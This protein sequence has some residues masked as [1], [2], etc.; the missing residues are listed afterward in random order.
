MKTL[1]L[2]NIKKSYDR[3]VL[4]GVSYMFLPGRLYVIKGV[5]GCGKSTLFNI[6]GGVEEDFDGDVTVGGEKMSGAQIRKCVGYVYQNSLLLSRVSIFDNLA[7]INGDRGAVTKTARRLGIEKHLGKLPEQ[8]SGGER[9]R[10]AVA[11]SLIND[12]DILL[13]DEPTASL[14][15]EN[16]RRT[17]ELIASLRRDGRIVLVA[18]HESCFD[19]LADE[20]LYL[21]YGQIERVDVRRPAGDTE[22]GAVYPAARKRE[23]ARGVNFLRFALRRRRRSF[24]PA[25]LLP[26]ALVVLLVMLVSTAAN[27]F[28]AEYIRYA[29]SSTI[30]D[31]VTVT[32]E[33]FAE[34]DAEHMAMVRRYDDLA[35]SDGGVTALYLADRKDSWLSLPG[36][37]QYGRFP[38]SENE[39]IVSR[40]YADLKETATGSMVGQ[41]VTFAG[42]EFTV[43]GVLYSSDRVVKDEG[44]SKNFE[45]N[46]RSDYYYRTEARRDSEDVYIYIPHDTLAKFGE[47]RDCDYIM[48]S[49]PGIFADR[50][51]TAYFRGWI[52]ANKLSEEER[53]EL[54]P[55]M[56]EHIESIVHTVNDFDQR[57]IT[58]S[59]T[60]GEISLVILAAYY[61]CFIIFCIFIKSQVDVELHYR[62]REIGFLQ[63]FGVRRVRIAAIVLS[64][65]LCRFLASCALAFAL[66][67]SVAAVYYAVAGS[68][69]FFDILYV[70]AAIGAAMIFYLLTITVSIRAAMKKKIIELIT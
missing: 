33:K 36:M 51:T 45:L 2:H 69:V 32:E 4:R 25:A 8:L 68:F 20:I 35:A 56:I 46:Y 67:A 57:A 49:Y 54:T 6:I 9:Q 50:D 22:T 16:S 58:L 55:D 30:S 7:L 15:D 70:T 14:D 13:L 28:E 62:R 24:R 60:L 31:V 19:A 17:A 10:A 18:T 37:I 64:E 23:R 38:A 41:S 42:R 48:F 65:Y 61:I 39:I 47:V 59:N 63:L 29:A 5:S 11:R 27:S 34:L 26:F 12:P 1:E 21:H 3:L 52:N 66:Y 44:K 53:A 40:E 43:A